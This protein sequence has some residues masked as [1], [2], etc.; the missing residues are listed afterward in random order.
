VKKNLDN[1]VLALAAV[2]N[3]AEL[4]A[5]V[6]VEGSCDRVQ[7]AVM[8]ESIFSLESESLDSIYAGRE[9]LLPGLQSLVNQFQPN[10]SIRVDAA[11]Y[12]MGLIQ[13]Q[14]QLMKNREAQDALRRG[15]TQLTEF[16]DMHGGEI[17]STIVN[18]LSTLYQDTLSH[19]KPRIIIRGNAA[20][21]AAQD[22]ADT[23]RALL[24]AGVRAAVLWRQAGGSRWSL[25]LGRRAS[26]QTA[27]QMVE[28]L[29]NGLPDT[30]E[31]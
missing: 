23:V 2:V 17:D 22:K 26:I 21:L 9:N 29:Q 18:R 8:L 13:L 28:S 15:V 4:V 24:M 3:C 11:Q 27:K 25:L 6:A 12:Q 1:Q 16:R 14:F 7:R 5:D 19:L 20:N 10:R 30:R 31:D